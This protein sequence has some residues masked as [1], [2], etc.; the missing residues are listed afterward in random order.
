[1]RVRRLF[2]PLVALVA[3]CLTAGAQPRSESREPLRTLTT[4][5]EVHNLPPEQA[6]RAYP[7]RLRAVV[8]YYDPHIDSRHGALFVHDATGCVF[9]SVPVRPILPL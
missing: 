1:M 5:R 6:V 3:A 9:V 2:V 8:T 4:T 7:V